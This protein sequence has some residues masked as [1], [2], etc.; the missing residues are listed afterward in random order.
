M[1]SL[2]LELEAVG[3]TVTPMEAMELIRLADIYL[4]NFLISFDLHAKLTKHIKEITEE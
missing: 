1:K 3:D 4:D 2:F